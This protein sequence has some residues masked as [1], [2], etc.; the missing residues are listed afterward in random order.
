MRS[1]GAAVPDVQA[2]R[3]LSA[4]RQ[5]AV[6]GYA[7][8]DAGLADFITG[9]Q[10]YHAS[11]GPQVEWLLPGVPNVRIAM[12]AGP[13]AV[14]IGKR[15]FDP[16]P[17]VTLT[18]PTT[19]ALRATIDGTGDDNEGGGRLVAFGLTPL[20]WARLVRRSAA[21]LRDR[22]VPLASV[23]GPELPDAL[24][25]ELAAAGGEG[26]AWARALDRMLAPLFA[27]PAPDEP[28][29]A[30]LT[31]ILVDPAVVSVVDAAERSGLDAALLRRV[32]KQHF[33]MMPKLLLRRSRFLRSFLGFFRS[34][35]ARG[36]AGIDPSYHDTSHFLR[37][38]DRFL[39][40]TPRRFMAVSTPFLDASLRARAAALGA[41]TC[42]LHERN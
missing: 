6:I 23:T 25:R 7:A 21:D 10:I 17:V 42:V 3:P 35:D 33:G 27:D 11:G 31:A 38:A 37:D 24:V 26:E 8:P 19:H 16:L 32:S 40:T 15:C 20:G 29:I 28:A 41:S 1:R 14:R 34:G 18:G 13:I 22:M 36:Y 12:G 39:G 4:I 5:D 9:Y 2:P 30:A